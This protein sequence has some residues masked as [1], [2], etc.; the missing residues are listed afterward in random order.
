MLAESVGQMGHWHWDIRTDKVTWS[1]QVFAI[2][3]VDPAAFPH[4]FAAALETIHP[5]DRGAVVAAFDGAV[6]N[7]APFEFDCRIQREDGVRTVI[8]KGQPEYD[9]NSAVTGLFGVLADVTDA[10]AA[11]RAIHDQKEMLGLAAHLA[12]MSAIGYGPRMRTVFRSARKSSR[13]FTIFLPARWRASFIPSNLPRRRRLA[14]AR[15]ISPQLRKRSR[16]PAPTRSSTQIESGRGV[17][18][19]IREIGQP[20][21]DEHGKLRRFIATVQDI[22]ETKRRENELA[23]AEAALQE[24]NRQKD[25]LFSI[26]AHDLAVRSIP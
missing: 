3:G 17:V 5:D 24:S 12:K 9:V 21:V 6:R 19:D 22:S 16:G 4:T 18:K 20:I 25:K 15:G 8:C 14:T 26:I 1:E 10:F 7:R 11:I 2:H 23:R 13:V